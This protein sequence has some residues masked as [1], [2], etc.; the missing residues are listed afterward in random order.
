MRWIV[1]RHEVEAL[2]GFGGTSERAADTVDP[3]CPEE[4][5]GASEGDQEDLDTT[6]SVAKKGTIRVITV[7]CKDHS[8]TRS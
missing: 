8:F 6:S 1:A 3:T 2:G 4:A 5:K 7:P